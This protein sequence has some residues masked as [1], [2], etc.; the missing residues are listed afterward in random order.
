MPW[1]GQHNVK[2]HMH[3]LNLVKSILDLSSTRDVWELQ[4]L[5]HCTRPF[6]AT[7][8]RD[9]VFALL[10]LAGETETPDNWPTALAPNYARTT[11]DVY[12]EVTRYCIQKTKNLSIL[13]QVDGSAE[14]NHTTNDLEFPS[15]V[16]RWDIPQT[17]SSLSA[18]TVIQNVAGW[19]TLIEL[20]NQASKQLPVSLDTYTSNEVLRL[21]GI[22]I[23]AVES[24]LPAT[25]PDQHG[26]NTSMSAQSY[27]NM[28]KAIPQLYN[29]C[30]ERLSHLPP[31]QFAR[32][33]FHVTTAGL[34][35]EHMDAR[36]EP[37][38]HFRA[39]L[40]STAPQTPEKEHSDPMYSLRTALKNN[41]SI[42]TLNQTITPSVS[43]EPTRSSFSRHRS[44]TSLSHSSFRSVPASDPDQ[45]DPTRYASALTPL[46]NRRLFITSS[47]HLGL[48][49]TSITS[50][51]VIVVLFGGKVPFVLRNVTG[52]QWRLIGECYVEGFMQGE[53]LVFRGE[54]SDTGLETEWFDLV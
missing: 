43:T 37:I 41:L 16:P 18:F 33:F 45:P 2:Y 11:R 14:A 38:T 19:R 7:D 39:F 27:T 4:A 51:D 21:E 32:T 52:D 23:G 48:G 17:T 26:S 31:E 34:T 50:G 5:L 9:K 29:V 22:C 42:S 49:P 25:F 30:K 6:K 1:L 53:G 44:S 8:P 10:G 15:W 13:T 12:M 20:F 35:L 3:R 28:Q 46:I 47:K 24:C 54:T 40:L 36:H